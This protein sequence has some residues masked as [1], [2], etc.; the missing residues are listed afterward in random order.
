VIRISN[1][2]LALEFMFHSRKGQQWYARIW[3]FGL[4]PHIQFFDWK[5]RKAETEGSP[6]L[7]C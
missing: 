1:G 7:R 6:C 4:R 5:K 2:N 3:R